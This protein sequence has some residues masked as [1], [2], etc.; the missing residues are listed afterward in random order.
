M[1]KRYRSSKLLRGGS[2][3]KIKKMLAKRGNTLSSLSGPQKTLIRAQL[4]TRRGYGKYT[5]LS[6]EQKQKMLEQKK[7]LKQNRS[8]KANNKK[9]REW[10]GSFMSKE[11][12]NSQLKPRPT[13][14]Q[15]PGYIAA[16]ANKTTG[17]PELNAL[18]RFADTSN[19]HSN[20]TNNSWVMINN[21]DISGKRGRKGKKTKRGKKSKRGN[22]SKKKRKSRK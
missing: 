1:N 8:K 2:L 17:D 18:I 16:S 22:N 6:R 11:Q 21:T 10:M 12:V 9:T 14:V 15:I 5:S 19:K 7:K 4:K 20:N 3:N 13:Q